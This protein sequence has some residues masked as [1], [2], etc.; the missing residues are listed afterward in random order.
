MRKNEKGMER[1]LTRGRLEKSLP[2]MISLRL[3]EGGVLEV[4]ASFLFCPR[5]MDLLGGADSGMLCFE[6]EEG[7]EGTCTGDAGGA[8]AATGVRGR[9]LAVV[10]LLERSPLEEPGASEG[11]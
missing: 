6:E 9:F 10:F 2:L 5:V 1:A 8:V 3:V 4:A 11:G 7:D